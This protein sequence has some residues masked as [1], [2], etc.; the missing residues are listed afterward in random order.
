VAAGV[1]TELIVL[2]NSPGQLTWLPPLLIAGE[3]AAAAALA[4][5]GRARIRHAVLAA[6]LALLMWAPATWAVDTLGHP[7]NGTF[8]SGGPTSTAMDFGG[9]GGGAGGGRFR[10][11]FP[12]GAGG[13]PPGGTAQGGAARGGFGQGGGFGGGPPTGTPGGAGQGG[14][15]GGIFGGNSDLPQAEAYV[16][17][18]GG[19]TI[20]VSSQTGAASQ[21]I[22]TGANVA[23]IGGFSGRESAVTVKWLAQEVAAGKIRWV[24]DGGTGGGMQ[25][26]RTGSSQV[27]AAVAKIGKQVSYGGSGTLYDLQGQASALLS[28]P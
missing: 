12:G 28:A 9:R 26:G 15:G 20:V 10:G 23:G 17:Q 3:I 13:G 8:P 6:A 1:V 5:R 7:T 11:G 16:N 14:P 24:L 19:G 4:V 25:D 21:I 22:T 2:H 27:M 18:H